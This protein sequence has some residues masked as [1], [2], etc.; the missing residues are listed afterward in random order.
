MAYQS[1]SRDSEYVN[2]ETADQIN[3]M[4]ESIESSIYGKE[5]VY[6]I[7]YQ[8]IRYLAIDKAR[9]NSSFIRDG[10]ILTLSLSIDTIDDKLKLPVEIPGIWVV[11]VSNGEHYSFPALIRDSVMSFPFK[12]KRPGPYYIYTVII[13]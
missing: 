7:P 11:S 9:S 10:H 4:I 6:D 1:I 3:T 13:I 12:P 8:D 2:P 5:T